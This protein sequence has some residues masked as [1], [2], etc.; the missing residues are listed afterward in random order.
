VLESERSRSLK[1][2]LLR[3]DLSTLRICAFALVGP[4]QSPY[5]AFSLAVRLQMCDNYAMRST[6]H[7]VEDEPGPGNGHYSD[8]PL[9]VPVAELLPVEGG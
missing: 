2:R 1:E 5:A 7:V 3:T 8:P 9:L 4:R 6:R